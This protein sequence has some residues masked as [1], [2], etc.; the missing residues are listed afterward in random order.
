MRHRQLL[1]LVVYLAL[2]LLVLACCGGSG[3]RATARR[4]ERWGAFD[5]AE[6]AAYAAL[7]G[8]STPLPSQL[9][10]KVEEALGPGA[11]PLRLD[12]APLIATPRGGLR[13]IAGGGKVC[14]VEARH[15][16]LACGS[17][18]QFL[19]EGLAIGTFDPPRHRGEPPTGFAVFGVVP[20]WA[21]AV[22]VEVGGVKRTLPVRGNGYAVA[23][24]QPI[25]V[26]RLR[27]RE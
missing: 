22:V 21:R 2:A 18:R 11:A 8:A 5:P 10:Q 6:L 23:A 27:R 3:D 24:P 19:H 26:D 12:R 7:G 25:I 17:R 20:D 15:G 1:A 4:E 9:R 16:A 13:V 14:I